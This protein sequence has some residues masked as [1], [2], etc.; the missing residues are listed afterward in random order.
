MGEECKSANN[1]PHPQHKLSQSLYNFRVKARKKNA[2]QLWK[3]Y[4]YFFSSFAH[5]F[6]NSW[7]RVCA[8]FCFC[9]WWGTWLMLNLPVHRW[10]E[11]SVDYEEGSVGQS[12]IHSAYPNTQR[13]MNSCINLHWHTLFNKHQNRVLGRSYNRAVIPNQWDT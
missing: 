5:D 11:T 8:G 4:I 10:N 2:C 6:Q 9:K 3:L 12:N 1:A 7:T 13:N